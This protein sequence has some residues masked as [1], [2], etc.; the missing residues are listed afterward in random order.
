MVSAAQEFMNQNINNTLLLL[1]KR[2]MQICPVGFLIK[3][4]HQ[5]SKINWSLTLFHFP[6][7][8]FDSWP[9]LL[10]NL[11]RL[12]EL[13]GLSKELKRQISSNIKQFRTIK[14]GTRLEKSDILITWKR[15]KV[16]F[17]NQT[18]INKGGKRQ[19]VEE[20]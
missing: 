11:G 18:Q 17:I 8:L 5:N 6:F 4:K 19:P 14:A 13:E 10:H 12:W 7:L 3:S 15:L 20:Q 2:R 1:S 16:S 9:L